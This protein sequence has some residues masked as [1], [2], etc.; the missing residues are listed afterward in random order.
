M[1][2][3]GS[4]TVT[5][6]SGGSSN[7]STKTYSGGARISLSETVGGAATDQLH[8]FALDLSPT[9]LFYMHSDV[10]M[11]VEFNSNAGAGGTIVLVADV[12][13]F[14]TTDTIWDETTDI[15]ADITAVYVTNASG[16]SGTITIEAIYDP[17]V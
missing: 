9:K 10:A 7:T 2:F 1:A 13:Y 12:P 17:T 15:T 5:I 4:L 3:S 6:V 8:A 11:T 14:F 16:T